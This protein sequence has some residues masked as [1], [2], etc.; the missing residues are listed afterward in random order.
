MQFKVHGSGKKNLHGDGFAIWYTKERL[1]PG[2]C[3]S[4]D[5][6]KENC[7]FT[8]SDHFHCALHDFN[9]NEL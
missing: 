5:P 1:H 8:F 6:V 4:C 9:C 7:R 3:E 2:K